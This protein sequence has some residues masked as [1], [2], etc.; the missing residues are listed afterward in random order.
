MARGVLTVSQITRTGLTQPA[1]TVGDATNGHQFANDGKYTF[2]E[3]HNTGASS[4]TVSIIPTA[5]VDGLTATP[6]VVTVAAGV[7]KKIGPFPL[8][9]Y[10]STVA[11]DVTHAEL[12]LS[13]FKVSEG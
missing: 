1:E 3:A 8:E 12:Q 4:R 6:R 13:V 2:F 7:T 11:V 9:I 10:S 5:S